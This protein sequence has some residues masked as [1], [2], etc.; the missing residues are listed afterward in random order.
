MNSYS[1]VKKLNLNKYSYLDYLKGDIFTWLTCNDNFQIASREDKI[2]RETT[3]WRYDDPEDIKIENDEESIERY[4]FHNETPDQ[5][6]AGIRV[7]EFSELWAKNKWPNHK[8]SYINLSTNLE[9]VELTSKLLTEEN[10]ILFE[11]TFGY[12]DFYIRTDILV[13]TGEE[14]KVIEVKATSSPKEVHAYDLFF[15]KEV[16]E[17]SNNNFK[18]WDYS[19]LILNKQYLHNKKL[20]IE[21]KKHEIAKGVFINIDYTTNGSLS[22]RTIPELETKL[23]WSYSNNIYFFNR[24]DN[25]QIYPTFVERKGRSSVFTFPISDF[26]E[27]SIIEE[28]KEKFDDDLERI[29]KIQLMDEPPLLEFE[30]RNNKFM[31]SDYFTWALMKSGAF[32]VDGTSVFELRKFN[33]Q[34]K[35]ELMKKNKLNLNEASVSD[36]SP[37]PYNDERYNNSE[38]TSLIKEFKQLSSSSKNI[39]KFNGIIQ[40]HFHNNEEELFHKE[41]I[42]IE[43]SKYKKAPIYMYDFETANLAIPFCDGTSPYE[44]VVY[45]YSIHVITDADDFDFESGKNVIHYEWL[46][47][48]KDDFNLT[49]WKEFVKV[50]KKHGAGTY[51]AWNMS[52]EKG[53]L[54]RAQLDYL[55]DDEKELIETIRNETEDLMLTFQKKFY[56]HKNLKGSYS[57]KYA[58]PH[59]AKEINY[60]NLNNVQKGDQSAAVAKKWLR[61]NSDESEIFWKSMREDMLKYCEYDTLLMVA[62]FQRMKERL[63]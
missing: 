53:C 20:N 49:A 29:K 21:E 10:I 17:R 44:Q 26:F 13:K 41:G 50:F 45:Q 56:Y 51:V 14:I 46:A 15:Q 40:K 60:K 31:S 47:E 11:A 12:N 35:V 22:E 30:E 16:I 58:G 8:V 59:F 55:N 24:L 4:D 25:S 34:K 42:D 3:P 33:F 28:L 5:M 43:L 18:N 36:I 2:L 39:P 61:D 9:N 37:K 38:T 52:F 62:I 6:K 27:S 32:D 19:L 48:N 63:V 57:I 7:G 54:S 1:G 23:K